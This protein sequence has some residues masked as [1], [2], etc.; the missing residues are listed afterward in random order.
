MESTVKE[1]AGEINIVYSNKNYIINQIE[2]IDY[3]EI[4]DKYKPN[5]Y[6]I[7][8]KEKI[9]AC[10]NIFTSLYIELNQDKDK[11]KYSENNNENYNL[12]Y[13]LYQLGDKNNTNI[14]LLDNKFSYG[15]RGT[16]IHKFESYDTL[17]IKLKIIKFLI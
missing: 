12:I 13:L 6:N 17:I 9:F 11:E 5:K 1:N 3:Y 8:F 4:E 14:E 15:L 10:D 7:V 16:L 2:N